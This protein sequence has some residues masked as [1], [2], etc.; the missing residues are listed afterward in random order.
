MHYFHLTTPPSTSEE[1]LLFCKRINSNVQPQFVPVKPEGPVDYCLPNV[2]KKV[3]VSGGQ[4]IEGWVIWLSNAT[5][6]EA[7]A[8]VVWA[9]SNLEMVDVT[10]KHDG[11]SLIL[12]LP[13]QKAW[14]GNESMSS[15]Q[16]ALVDN[17]LTR[18]LIRKSQ[19]YAV[20]RRQ[21]WNGQQSIIPGHL[22]RELDK[23]FSEILN[24]VS[25]NSRCPCKSGKNFRVCCG[26]P[27]GK[28]WSNGV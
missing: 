26:R 8:H 25:P 10:A 11:E 24:G 16:L 13:D 4:A 17:Q 23:L 15:K 22:Y 9:N 12:F 14:E 27:P 3:S 6:I 7:E 1:V 20:L 2:L 18:A 21:Y 28:P 19:R 5:F